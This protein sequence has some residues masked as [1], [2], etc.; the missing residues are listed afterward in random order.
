MRIRLLGPATDV[1]GL[2]PVGEY[3]KDLLEHSEPRRSTLNLCVAYA[4]ETFLEPGLPDFQTFVNQGGSVEAIIGV[5]SKGTSHVAL[6]NLS[7]IVPLNNLL[8]YHNP[9]DGTFHPKF[10]IFR[11]KSKA[12]II[13]G[14]SNLTAGGLADNFELNVTIELELRNTEEK[15]VFRSAVDLFRSIKRS[16][17]CVPFSQSVLQGLVKSG[18]LSEKRAEPDALS[19]K[20]ANRLS[21]FFKG[22]PH[23]K[24][25]RRRPKGAISYAFV[26]PLS[27]H[28][29]SGKREPYF[30]IPI[31]ARNENPAFWG[32]PRRFAKSERG[33]FPERRFK[34]T[35]RHRGSQTGEDSRMYYV[36]GK[37]EFRFKCKRVHG[38]GVAK[39]GSLVKVWWVGKR[40]SEIANL[41]LIERTDGEYAH[42][43]RIVTTTPAKPKA[44]AY[45]AT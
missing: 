15:R 26:M 4:K 3:L 38:L 24:V 14:S 29:V 31:A 8:V 1:C 32:W 39:A 5:D 33:G 27:E 11:S 34:L 30:L 28:D 42:L 2:V 43:R 7:K 16:P 40:G 13:V 25:H 36:D 37:K 41:A 6:S 23:T 21:S 22:T 18:A 17:S 19:R 12:S 35:F 9:A 45:V 44:Y 10:Y 20:L